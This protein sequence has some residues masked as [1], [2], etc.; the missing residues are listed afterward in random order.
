MAFNFV[1]SLILKCVINKY[2]LVD[3]RNYSNWMVM[4]ILKM[5]ITVTVYIRFWKKEMKS[6]DFPSLLGKDKCKT[7]LLCF[8]RQVKFSCSFL[9]NQWWIQDSLKGDPGGRGLGAAL[10]P[11][12]GPAP[13]SSS[14]LRC[15]ETLLWAILVMI[16]IL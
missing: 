7:F 14:V 11:P 10:R 3:N 1:K 13:G 12:V 8:I 16:D 2:S 6:F 5:K 4:Q 9:N 15:L